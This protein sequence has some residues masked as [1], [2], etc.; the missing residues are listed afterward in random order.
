ME[1]PREEGTPAVAQPMTSL[2]SKQP[3]LTFSL[4]K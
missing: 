4:L 3:E 1:C 2:S